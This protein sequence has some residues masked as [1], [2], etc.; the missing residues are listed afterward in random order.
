MDVNLLEVVSNLKPQSQEHLMACWEAM[1]KF[2]E[3][4][5]EMMED[6][7]EKTPTDSPDYDRQAL[8]R[9]IQARLQA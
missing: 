7:L 3:E 6:L 9:Q 8:L 2:G 5:Y 1:E 4:G